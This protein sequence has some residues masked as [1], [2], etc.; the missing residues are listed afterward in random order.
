MTG[1][2]R[3]G[4]SGGTGRP[5]RGSGGGG[6]SARGPEGS[7]E[8]GIPDSLLVGVI[9]FLV[10]VTLLM[11]SAA[12][13]AGLL[14]KGAW[15]D[16]VTFLRTPIA[17]RSL[18]SEPHDLAAA[19]PETP[20]DQLSGYGLFWGLFIGQLMVLFVLTVFA[21]GTTARYRIV[22]ARR[23]EE[24]VDRRAAA[25][26]AAVTGA[27]DGG[28]TG[29]EK[30]SGRY[31]RTPGRYETTAADDEDATGG[32]ADTRHGTG[33]TPGRGM[34]NGA[35][36]P[37]GPVPAAPAAGVPPQPANGSPAASY[38]PSAAYG[39]QAEPM[40]AQAPA[41]PQA[42]GQQPP[43]AAGTSVA[44]PM[45]APTPSMAPGTPD[46]AAR[47]ASFPSPEPPLPRVLYGAQRG[48]AAVRTVLDAEGPV[49]VVTSAPEVWSATKDARAKLGAVHVFD[50]AHLLDT[51]ARLRWNPATGCEV[52]DVAAARAAALLAPVRPAHALDRPTA[53]AAETLMR[54]W[55]HAA[56]VDGRPFRQVHRWA[57][58]GS[59]H[60]PVR[61]L[62]T[63]P[64]ALGG[65]AGELEATLT[66]H[67]ERR[68]LARELTARALS[69]LSSIHIRDA[70]NPGRAD[71]LAL[72][73]FIAEGG[74][75]YLVGE[76]IEDPR[77]H[78]GAMPLLTALA[79]S[80]VEHGR[81]MAERSSSGRLDP[82]VTLVLDDVAAVAP[83]PA[84]PD[85]IAQG[86]AQGLLTLALMRSQEQA[87]ARWPH[88]AL[89][90]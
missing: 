7:P 55:L 28:V 4:G 53:E 44:P 38:G 67:P 20:A 76:S 39:G 36:P 11:W 45:E 49:L 61:I 8:R 66:A 52:R 29:Y 90:R 62:R 23:R 21:I 26:D 58:G 63:H 15:P 56:A 14:A 6:G 51:P 16:N 80:V 41:A 85:L 31:D 40:M 24:A 35:A 81:R 65:V 54:C 77:A 3:R 33:P 69:A 78:P 37:P 70:C 12:G 48:D 32:L 27:P 72:E 13:L 22:R 84:L 57:Q 73:S 46:A 47:A 87:R 68:D 59:A 79:S 89:V 64:K 1:D 30:P 42:A 83:I 74:T 5:G 82:P 43:H 25:K 18:I 2:P 60:E 10:G 86:A 9:G 75:L 88:R 19:W 71:A 50:P 34:A 17:L